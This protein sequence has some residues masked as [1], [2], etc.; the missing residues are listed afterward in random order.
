MSKANASEPLVS[1]YHLY[2]IIQY[3]QRQGVSQ[4]DVLASL[5]LS[6]LGKSLAELPAVIPVRKFSE[7]GHK[8]KEVSG[9][10]LVCVRAGS[11]QSS[12]DFSHLAQLAFNCENARQALELYCQYVSVFNQ[13][14]PTELAFHSSVVDMPIENPF[15][16]A[17]EAAPIMELRAAN[18]LRILR[19]MTGEIQPDFVQQIYFQ[20]APSADI[21]EY[22][23]LLKA[24]VI[25]NQKKS[26]CKL[27]NWLLDKPVIS[28]N[29]ERLQGAIEDVLKQKN[30]LED[31]SDDLLLKVKSAIRKGLEDGSFS[32]K[33]IAET[34]GLS[35]STLKRRL[36]SKHSKFQDMIDEVRD[37]EVKQLLRTTNISIEQIAKKVAYASVTALNQAFKR[38]NNM[39]PSEYR[40]KHS[41]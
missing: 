36:A 39:S 21:A 17:E 26:G 32:Q 12:S 41:S 3:F 2:P 22:E 23:K 31:Y 35:I 1:T 29:P 19:V 40:Q 37:T 16:S 28:H 25:F 34:L 33:Q 8:A 18:Y 4:T 13:A 11:E 7:V 24:P 15:F 20:H 6:S 14:F 27:H 10:P 30:T 5:G 9:D 38:L